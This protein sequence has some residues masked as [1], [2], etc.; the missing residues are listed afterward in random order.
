M[1]TE[2]TDAQPDPPAWPAC[3]V[4]A[5]DYVLRRALIMN[6]PPGRPD[7][8]WVWQPD[9]KCRHAHGMLRRRGDADGT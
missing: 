7:Y 2:I 3:S 9:C 4:C 5:T 8:A 1:A 6:R